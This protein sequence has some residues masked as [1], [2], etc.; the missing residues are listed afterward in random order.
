MRGFLFVRGP[1]CLVE[2]LVGHM[3]VSTAKH[4]INESLNANVGQRTF[5]IPPP[6]STSN[7][8]GFQTISL[9]G[10]CI[11]VLG[12][13][14]YFEQKE[15]GSKPRPLPDDVQRVM[16]NGSWLMRDGSIRPASDGEKR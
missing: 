5:L 6:S 2:S 15:E 9:W 16:P 1:G 4:P 14:Y 7:K 3:P 12:V 8:I 13:C 10:L 11:V